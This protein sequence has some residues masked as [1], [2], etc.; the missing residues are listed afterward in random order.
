M[1]ND[2]EQILSSNYI[3]G[4]IFYEREIEFT[5]KD[6]GVGITSEE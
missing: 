3:D 5:V 6:S 2:K 1:K 4:D